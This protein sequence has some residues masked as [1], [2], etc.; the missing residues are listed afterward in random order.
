MT[1]NPF[2]HHFPNMLKGRINHVL[3][4]VSQRFPMLEK[5]ALHAVPT[6]MTQKTHP[7]PDLETLDK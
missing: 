1:T 7:R 5:W 3:S 2:H 4:A 6:S